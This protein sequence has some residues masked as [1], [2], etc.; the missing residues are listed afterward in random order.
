MLAM[1]PVCDKRFDHHEIDNGTDDRLEC[2]AECVLRAALVEAVG[3]LR[4]A[5]DV[6]NL[7]WHDK[8]R[9]FL[10]TLDGGAK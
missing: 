10:A 6:I 9:R 8:R 2:S 3:L 1:C 5:S 7:P 4:D